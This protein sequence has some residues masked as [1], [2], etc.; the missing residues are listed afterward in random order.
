MNRTARARK[1]Q[2]SIPLRDGRVPVGH[3]VLTEAEWS[4]CHGLNEIMDGRLTIVSDTDYVGPS[5]PRCRE[6]HAGGSGVLFA[7]ESPDRRAFAFLFTCVECGFSSPF[8]LPFEG[9]VPVGRR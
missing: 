3:P 4:S 8:K 9:R 7:G 2:S 1:G 5:C 6:Q